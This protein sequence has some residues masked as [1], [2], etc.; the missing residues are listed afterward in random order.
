M[1]CARG[2]FDTHA[3]K[4]LVHALCMIAGASVGAR[5]F[6]AFPAFPYAMLLAG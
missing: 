6:V 1:S 3:E 4:I 2:P 5:L